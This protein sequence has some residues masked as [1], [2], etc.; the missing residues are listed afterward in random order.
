MQQLQKNKVLFIG[1]V[2]LSF[3]V[4]S[5]IGTFGVLYF[6]SATPAG[7]TLRTKLGLDNLQTFNIQTSKTEK[8]IVEESSAIID[9]NK[10]INSSVVSIA[11]TGAPIRDIFGFRTPQ[12]SGTGFIVT[13][14]GLIATNKHVVDG[15]KDFTITTS[16]SKSYPGVVVSKDPVTDLALIKIEARGL[17]VADLGDS[18]KIQ[19]G[20]WVIAVGNALGE[21]Q[22]S[23]T[24][25][26]ISA[27][28][29]K[30]TPT[31]ASGKVENLDGLFQTDTAINPGNSGGPLVNL[32]GQVIGINT[33]IAGNAQNIGFAI[34]V[35]ELKKAL[36]S[37]RE[38]GKI[39]RPYIGVRYQALT[40][41]VASSL[42]LTVEKGAL[43]IG[44]STAPAIAAGSP[45]EKA[46]LKENDV[47]TRVDNQEITET[48][49]LGRITRKYN[50][51]DKVTLTVL[52]DGKTI[53]V[54]LTLGELS[55]D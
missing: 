3:L 15:G 18:D 24:V 54:E 50:P 6:L 30:A 51:G 26:V 1:G 32:K 5:V 10:K 43:I 47:I 42:K 11:G 38:N 12:T 14:D 52:R 39:V 29:R 7:E 28:E 45:A 31:D 23:V 20:Q 21:L 2:L 37:Y 44:S 16:D 36:D 53:S 33:A 35:N 41:A 4:V 25:G 17:P 22:N 8:I 34:Q 19:V 9:A 55:S 13:S 49:T 48:N 46:G 27:L 40:K